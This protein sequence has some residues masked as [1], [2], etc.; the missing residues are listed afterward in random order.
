MAPHIQLSALI[1]HVMKVNALDTA[2]LQHV[3]SCVPCRSDL[4]W[5]E[6]LDALRKF[7]PPKPA[8]QA[9]LRLFTTKRDAA[10]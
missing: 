5:L 7:E 8:V 1:D 9:A 10:A 6:Q 2:G 3:E 4:Q